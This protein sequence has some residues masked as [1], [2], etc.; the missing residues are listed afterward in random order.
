MAD[1]KQDFLEW[2]SR[3]LD[4]IDAQL[5]E[6]RTQH[7]DEATLGAKFDSDERLSTLERRREDIRRRS[8]E[9]EDF[10]GDEW[11]RARRELEQARNDL[12]ASLAESRNRTM[13]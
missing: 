10:E 7:G 1:R 2:L 9:L 13:H 11:E 3:D 5:D 12:K 8:K 6:W 4:A